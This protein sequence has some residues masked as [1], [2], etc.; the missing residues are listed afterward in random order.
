MMGTVDCI[1]SLARELSKE[2]EEQNGAGEAEGEGG[3]ARET[4]RSED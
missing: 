1:A 2:R 3:K 4:V